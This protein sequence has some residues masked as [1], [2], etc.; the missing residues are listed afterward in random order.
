MN[1]VQNDKEKECSKIIIQAGE[2][3]E[4]GELQ[5]KKSPKIITNYEALKRLPFEQLFKLSTEPREINFETVPDKVNN[6]YAWHIK[7]ESNENHCHNNENNHFNNNSFGGYYWN[8]MR[9][10]EY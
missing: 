5:G 4:N 8:G 9:W 1:M 7:R 10:V 3:Y 6:I 2:K